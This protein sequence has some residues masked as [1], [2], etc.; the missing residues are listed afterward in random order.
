MRYCVIIIFILRW[1]EPKMFLPNDSAF[2]QKWL[3]DLDPNIQVIRHP[4]YILPFMWSHHEKSCTIDQ[5]I[6]YMGG[7]DLCYGRYDTGQHPLF[8]PYTSKNN[9]IITSD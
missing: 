3:M 8:D 5:K 9:S 2:T 4:D 7:L 1:N 6:S